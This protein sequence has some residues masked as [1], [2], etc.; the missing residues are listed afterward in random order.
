[1]AKASRVIQWYA[2]A[3]G[4]LLAKIPPRFKSP[5]P[6]N[7]ERVRIV[8]IINRLVSQFIHEEVDK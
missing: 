2:R 8:C 4:K 7:L 6:R 1:M 3:F 5:D